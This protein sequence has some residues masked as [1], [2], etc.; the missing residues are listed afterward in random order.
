MTEPLRP[1]EIFSSGGVGDALIIGMKIQKANFKEKVIWRHFERHDCHGD[2]CLDIMKQFVP[3]SEMHI[4]EQPE[5]CAKQM[6]EDVGGTYMDSRVPDFP[7][8]YLNNPIGDG[9]FILEHSKLAF[10][11]GH[12]V[13]QQAAGRMH[14]NTKRV[15]G[16]S[17]I[18][19]LYETFPDR[20]VVVVG[21]LE[22]QIDVPNIINL[23]GQ[24][25]SVVDALQTVNDCSLFV[26]HDGVM[27][28]YAMMLRKWSI[29]NYHI[30]TLVNHYWNP[31]WKNHSLAVT[32]AGTY[33]NGLP[34]NDHVQ[35][36]F[37]YIRSN[38]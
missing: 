21:P 11:K 2:P 3:A 6:C 28:Y 1:M 23:T 5:K 31:S 19:G 38:N 25:P 13:I 16:E 30:P 4:M 9:K 34:V 15:I 20:S 37:D 32:G 10:L 35:K 22:T 12:I 24:T 27:A 17:L 33:L 18:R 7:S 29:V 36:M 14:D 8:P 26:G